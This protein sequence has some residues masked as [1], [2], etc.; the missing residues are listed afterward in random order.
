MNKN[1]YIVKKFDNTDYINNIIFQKFN[2]LKESDFKRKSHLFYGR[3]ENIYIKRNSI[4]EIKNTIDKLKQEAALLLDVKSEKLRFG[5]WF[6]V[7]S[8]GD[9]TTVHC[10]DDLDEI[11]SGVYYIRVPARSGNLVLHMEKQIEI[12]P[13]EGMLVLFSPSLNHHVS[14]N[15]STDVRVSIGFNVTILDGPAL[16]NL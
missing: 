8:P 1:H 14:I 12:V 15:N 7:M 9:Q 5:F 4:P 6:N 3:Y 16:G 13:E 10:H 11:L 2:D